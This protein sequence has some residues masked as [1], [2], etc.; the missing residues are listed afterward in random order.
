MDDLNK[1]QLTSPPV[2]DPNKTVMGSVATKYEATVTIK[3]IQCPVCKEFNPVGVMFCV[4]CGL[5][6]DKALDGDAF[7][8]PAVQLPILI[9][10]H[11]KEHILRPGVTTIGRQ[12]DI[13][14]EDPNL[15]RKHANLHL[16]GGKI[17]VE[18][19]DST[20]GT[21]VNGNKVEPN[22]K[23]PIAQGDVLAFGGVKLTLQLP[24][25]GAKTQMPLSGKTTQLD[26]PPTAGLRGWLVFQGE[27]TP[28]EIG[29][30]TFGRGANN[31]IVIADPY[32]SGAHGKITVT[33]TEI[34]L[35][36]LG[37]TNGTFVNG[38]RLAEGQETTVSPEDEIKLGQVEIAIKLKGAN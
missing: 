16:D 33:D 25:E 20:N 24:G 13:Q 7:G 26:G 35:Q 34:L 21:T 22:V 12:G 36:D 30:H 6:F 18:D 15:S 32:V 1:T 14:I 31:E 8:A 17:T 2:L 4:E 27:E 37:S 3:P 38:V 28:L 10:E 5:I 29:E 23:V 19:L 9:D 11:Q